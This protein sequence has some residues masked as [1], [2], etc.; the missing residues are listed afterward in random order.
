[1]RHALLV[2]HQPALRDSLRSILEDADYDADSVGTLAEAR[3]MLERGDYDLVMANDRLPDGRGFD[4][5]AAAQELGI[6]SFLVTGD[7]DELTLT[8]AGKPHLRK[9]VHA[10]ELLSALA[11]FADSD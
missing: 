7:A 6:T 2:G 8:P 3:S 4:A 11:D 5:A 1:M 9:H 10:A